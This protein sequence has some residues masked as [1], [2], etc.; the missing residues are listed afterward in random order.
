MSA[1][2]NFWHRYRS[3]TS[4]VFNTAEILYH[5]LTSKPNK[6]YCL[7]MGSIPEFYANG[8]L[9]HNC[10]ICRPM[11]GQVTGIREP[12]VHPQTGRLVT[13]PGHPRCRC[14]ETGVIEESDLEAVLESMVT[15]ANSEIAEG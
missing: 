5:I 12:W 15:V 3:F 11:E 6:V 4:F 14:R 13:I 7:N 8:I 10:P 9:V 1:V 2:N